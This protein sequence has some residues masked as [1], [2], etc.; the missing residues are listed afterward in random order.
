MPN[1]PCSPD[2]T[3]EDEF[4]GTVF[5]NALTPTEFMG[6][7]LLHGLSGLRPTVA[8][9]NT[10]YTER[11][12]LSVSDDKMQCKCLQVQANL[13]CTL[14]QTE[15]LERIDNLMRVTDAVYPSLRGSL[16]CRSC[17]DD[18][19]VIQVCSMVLK[20]LLSALDCGHNK[21]SV[22]D[23]R[24]GNYCPD[25][26]VSTWTASLLQHRVLS[27]FTR[28]LTLFRRRLDRARVS[29]DPGNRER[30]YL[31]QVFLSLEK[32]SSA[33]GSELRNT[34]RKLD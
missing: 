27:H 32:S 19:Q 22:I 25:R 26:N 5:N 15:E 12:I 14:R 1:T 7:S 3:F 31:E 34:L 28:L 11:D 9:S 21:P 16:Q 24:I 29:G 17:L 13:L 6:S 8:G 33:I 18:N 10:T 30:E 2:D 23:I 20:T 4:D